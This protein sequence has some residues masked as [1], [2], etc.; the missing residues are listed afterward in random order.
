MSKP[1]T[2]LTH[3]DW[4]IRIHIKMLQKI[5]QSLRFSVLKFSNN[6]QHLHIENISEETL[7]KLCFLT[8]TDQN[9]N[10]GYLEHF[11][12]Y[13]TNDNSKTPI[14]VPGLKDLLVSI[15]NNSDTD[16]FLAGKKTQTPF[17]HPLNNPITKKPMS[18]KD[19]IDM[20]TSTIPWSPK[21]AGQTQYYSIAVN[22]DF[23]PALIPLALL[24]I[25]SAGLA[26]GSS[27]H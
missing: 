6:T 17:L 13:T 14:S 21:T 7:P 27:I 11:H 18:I 20:I 8:N 24:G 10:Y 2:D 26:I 23:P 5:D 16:A 12:V 15:W 3:A 22:P 4:W 1:P 9:N 19:Y 25:G